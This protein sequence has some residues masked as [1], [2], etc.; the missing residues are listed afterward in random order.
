MVT[1]RCLYAFLLPALTVKQAVF[2]RKP[3]CSAA[4]RLLHSS[5]LKIFSLMFIK[6]SIKR[7]EDIMGSSGMSLLFPQNVAVL[8]E[9]ATCCPVKL[10]FNVV[11]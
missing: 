5:D 1:C 2:H 7:K 4:A 8:V 10:L 9:E 6:R 11:I 3:P